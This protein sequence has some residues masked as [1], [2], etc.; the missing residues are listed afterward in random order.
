MASPSHAQRGAAGSAARPSGAATPPTLTLV[1]AAPA[2]V[3]VQFAGATA[4]AQTRSKRSLCSSGRIACVSGSP[5]RQLY[6]STAGSTPLCTSHD[7]AKSKP[8]L[9][10]ARTEP[11]AC[12][13]IVYVPSAFAGAPFQPVE[14]VRCGSGVSMRPA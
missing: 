4:H 2:G 11:L 8:A 6:S 1:A 10:S 5:K 7:A 9:P 14:T 12:C 13:A 3:A